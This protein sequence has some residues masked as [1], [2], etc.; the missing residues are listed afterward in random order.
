MATSR[1]IPA[2][3]FWL[4]FFL[5]ASIFVTNA[6]AQSVPNPHIDPGCE[7]YPAWY[8]QMNSQTDALGVNNHWF[9]EYNATYWG[10]AFSYPL[11]T[12]LTIKGQYPEARYISF[13]L[14][15][16]NRTILDSINDVDINPDPGTNNP[17]RGGAAQGT[18]TVRVIFGRRPE[19]APANTLYTNGLSVAGVLYRV[20]YPDDPQNLPGGPV[21]PVL[22]QMSVGGVNLASCPPRP[23]LPE[24]ST[25][26]GRLDDIDFVGVPPAINPP[27]L[28]VWTTTITSPFLPFF[29]S[30]DSSYLA[31]VIDRDWL[32]PP[33]Q[34]DMVV[35]R[36]KVPTFTDTQAGVPPYAPAN[37]RFWSLCENEL[38]TTSVVRCVPDNKAATQNGYA[39]FVISDPSKRPSDAVLGQWGASWIAWGALLPTDVIYGIGGNALTNADGVFYYGLLIYRQV[40]ADPNFAQSIANVSQLPILQRPGAMGEYWPKIGYCRAA[41]F[42]AMGAGCI[43]PTEQ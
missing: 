40:E 18:Y 24:E 20:Y 39:T 10:T 7:N 35:V 38:I 33:F 23:I 3:S 26:S 27:I 43:R 37:V 9:P 19:R 32:L 1:S 12:V 31:A 15:D 4:G 34:N 29:P 14:Y 16:T 17:F 8:V 30:Q 6:T 25:L 13:Q 41:A 36:M 11:G 28:P 2:A 5:V 22:P 21:N 42:Q